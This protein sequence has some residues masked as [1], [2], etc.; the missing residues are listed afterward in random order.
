MQTNTK[1]KLAAI[2]LA[3]TGL[4]TWINYEESPPEKDTQGATSIPLK[5]PPHP[6]P[7]EKNI[8]ISEPT[9]QTGLSPVL[10][11]A[12]AP[13]KQKGYKTDNECIGNMFYGRYQKPSQTPDEKFS[14]LRWAIEE[15]SGNNMPETF[16]K[17]AAGLGI[18]KAKLIADLRNSAINVFQSTQT[19]SYKTDIDWLNHWNNLKIA[20]KYTGLTDMGEFNP[21]LS[22]AAVSYDEASLIRNRDAYMLN[23]ARDI[24]Q[25]IRE[26]FRGI[27]DDYVANIQN[28]ARRGRSLD[29]ALEKLPPDQRIKLREKVDIIIYVTDTLLSQDSQSYLKIG[30]DENT[31]DLLGRIKRSYMLDQKINNDLATQCKGEAFT[32]R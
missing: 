25:S 29:E 13:E 14:N 24:F 5:I 15:F 18:P 2:L 31:Y 4:A 27:N 12:S 8:G 28:G 3:A 16:D 6:K 32:P 20:L 10:N 26:E 11:A 7:P 9:S 19:S 21:A 23:G 30:I 22:A 17:A 1:F